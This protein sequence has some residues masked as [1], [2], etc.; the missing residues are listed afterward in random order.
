MHDSVFG[1]SLGLILVAYLL[2]LPLLTAYV[3]ESKG[4]SVFLWLLIGLLFGPV[5]LLAAVGIAPIDLEERRARQGRR[6]DKR[7]CPLCDEAV[8]INAVVCR[9]CRTDLGPAP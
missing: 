1:V 3:A 2:G 4:R 5:G 9:Y 6:S 7:I 8:W